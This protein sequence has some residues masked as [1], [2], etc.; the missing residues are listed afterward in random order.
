MRGPT[1]GGRG[2]S[3]VVLPATALVLSICAVA[4]A[5]VGFVL[6][7]SPRPDPANAA[8]GQ[9]H[10]V[11]TPRTPTPTPTPQP[12]THPSHKLKPK[13]KVDRSATYVVVFNNSNVSGLAAGTAAK[14]QA[15]GWNVIATDNWYGTVAAPT[16]YY[17]ARLQRAAKL[18][19]RDLGITRVKPAIDPMQMDRLTVILTAGYSG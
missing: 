7:S 15:V 17:P 2:E 10:R 5:A 3:G 1:A 13:P 12:R 6:T 9:I 4:A 16:V 14:A 11:A 8:S 19:A 18:L